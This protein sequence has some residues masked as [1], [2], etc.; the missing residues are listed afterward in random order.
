[1][2]T[3]A[4]VG[5]VLVSIV[6]IFGMVAGCGG[7][8]WYNTGI[9]LQETTLA[10]YRDNQNVYDNMWK[11]IVE[12]AQVPAQYKEDFKQILVADNTAKFGPDGSQ[13]SF[14]WFKER[15]ITLA[16]ELYLQV[17]RVIE[18]GRNDFRQGQTMLQDKQFRL[19]THRKQIFGAV[20]RAFGFDFLDDLNGELKPPRDLDGDG[21]YTVL[22]YDIVTSS[23]TKEAF[24]TGEDAPVKVFG[25][26]E[27]K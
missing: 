14:Q 16:P 9:S 27:A 7:C 5:I 3:K 11:K 2:S 24:Q 22:D 15:N 25:G 10:Q 19:R 23:R 17:Q 12:T 13:A 1:M 26:S 8:S 20:C 18:S 4:I 21:G 6:I